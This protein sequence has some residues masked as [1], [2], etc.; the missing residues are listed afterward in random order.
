MGAA[1]KRL[2]RGEFSADSLTHKAYVYAALVS[3]NPRV[4]ECLLENGC[5]VH[6][7]LCESTLCDTA[8][9]S[10][11]KSDGDKATLEIPIFVQAFSF[12][13]P[14]VLRLILE[15]AK[16]TGVL[17]WGKLSGTL[18][19]TFLTYCLMSAGRSALPEMVRLL[20]EFGLAP[21][22]RSVSVL[23]Q[24][25]EDDVPCVFADNASLLKEIFLKA[26]ASDHEKTR[27][28]AQML[29]RGYMYPEQCVNAGNAV[30]QHKVGMDP[31][32]RDIFEEIV[33]TV[34]GIVLPTFFADLKLRI[35]KRA[36][37][38]RMERPDTSELNALVQ[39]SSPRSRYL[40]QVFKAALESGFLPNM[41]Q[42]VDKQG[43]LRTRD[44]REANGMCSCFL[45]LGTIF[46]T[47]DVHLLDQLGRTIEVIDSA[48]QGARGREKWEH[49]V[50]IFMQLCGKE[51]DAGMLERLMDMF[52]SKSQGGGRD[53][54]YLAVASAVTSLNLDRVVQVAEKLKL[55]ELLRRDPRDEGGESSGSGEMKAA[56]TGNDDD[57]DGDED[58]TRGL[59]VRTVLAFADTDH[60]WNHSASM[61]F[62]LLC[63]LGADLTSTTGAVAQLEAMSSIPNG[64][65]MA[66]CFIQLGAPPLG[67]MGV[68]MA[69]STSG[70]I[71]TTMHALAVYMQNAIM[72]P[73]FDN[74]FT[75]EVDPDDTDKEWKA[76]A[77]E[78]M[79]DAELADGLRALATLISRM[80]GIHDL[81]LSNGKKID[82]CETIEETWVQHQI[83]LYLYSCTPTYAL[84]CVLTSSSAYLF[85]LVSTLF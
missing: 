83:R 60:A 51:L 68:E 75:S 20:L 39:E 61:I 77:N 66:E 53:R 31:I 17:D 47:M 34:C 3:K 11:G 13:S 73:F 74:D 70:R 57:G 43:D 10:D 80:G 54:V 24:H 29:M 50:N 9:K 40:A 38:N 59:L 4:M 56:G 67:V 41:M 42:D 36:D 84:H 12:A 19:D 15:K 26:D 2:E 82:A 35:L 8:G 23:G 63:D 6:Q 44:E 81:A 16:A 48:Q 25:G 65:A 45:L 69:T 64:S 85:H 62:R 32:P 79:Q 5:D 7:I 49:H 1:K 30:L 55:R 33:N 28:A 37:G 27:E 18:G 21:N 22:M 72:L 58:C 76:V 14:G 46:G 78:H 71:K 52:T